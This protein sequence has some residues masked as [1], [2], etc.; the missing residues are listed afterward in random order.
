M[1]LCSI[2]RALISKITSSAI[3]STYALE[4][5][6]FMASPC[7][8]RDSETATLGA[9]STGNVLNHPHG[10]DIVDPIHGTITVHPLLSAFINTPQFQRLR[11]IRM[12]GP[13]YFTFPTGNHNRFEHCIGVSYLA[14]QLV[15]TIRRNQ[16]EL[17]V[18][19]ADCLAVGLAGLCHDLGHGPLSHTFERFLREACPDKKPWDHE[20]FSISIMED[21]VESR[22]LMPLLRSYH[23]DE[24][25]LIFVK[26][27]IHGQRLVGRP[28]E[29]AFLYEIVSNKRNGI[30]VDRIDYIYRD[31]FNVPVVAC[32]P[33]RFSEVIDTA[34]AICVD[35]DWQICYAARF[36]HVIWELFDTRRELHRRLYQNQANGLGERMTLDILLAA[37]KHLTF[38]GP[39]GVSFRLTESLKSLPH[40]MMLN[41]GIISQIRDSFQPEMKTARDLL[42]R[43]FTNERYKFICRTDLVKS[44]GGIELAK[45]KVDLTRMVKSSLQKSPHREMRVDDVVLIHQKFDYG[46][47]EKNPMERI[48]FYDRSNLSAAVKMSTEDFDV[49][50]PQY[51]LEESVSLYYKHDDVTIIDE[52]RCAMCRWAEERKLRILLNPDNLKPL[53]SARNEKGDHDAILPDAELTKAVKKDLFSIYNM[54]EPADAKIKGEF[55]VLARLDE[56]E[57]NKVKP[58]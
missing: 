2:A 34:R 56:F 33:T 26:E 23:L 19:E 55:D 46:M 29:K 3:P 24:I 49:S 8:A 21:I 20:A 45:L 16:P 38:V 57:A 47:G 13:A 7:K 50:S 18:T 10:T 53:R 32:T 25:D 11:F 12:L 48:S 28:K 52:L 41:D 15:E 40:F 36:A 1:Y 14:M 44:L 51:W 30:D 6:V 22:N 5:Q 58:K 9:P 27:L 42:N 4:I 37:D 39:D 43:L 17:A 54:E 31:A 35:D